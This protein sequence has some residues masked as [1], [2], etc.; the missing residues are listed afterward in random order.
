MVF[1]TYLMIYAMIQPEEISNPK[2]PSPKHLQHNNYTS[3]SWANTKPLTITYLQA[4]KHMQTY[5]KESCK[6]KKPCENN[7]SYGIII[8]CVSFWSIINYESHIIDYLHLWTPLLWASSI[9]VMTPYPCTSNK[10]QQPF[11]T[12]RNSTK[13]L[14]RAPPSF[15]PNFTKLSSPAL[16]THHELSSHQQSQILPKKEEIVNLYYMYSQ[17]FS[18]VFKHWTDRNKKI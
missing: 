5:P 1:G 11:F 2:V 18:E 6:L 16:Y 14:P 15:K 12:K 8:D 4:M 10:I 7:H 9:L 13:T 3:Q 17:E